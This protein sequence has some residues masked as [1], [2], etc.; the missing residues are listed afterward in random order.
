M[1]VQHKTSCTTP[2]AG[3][4]LA[5][6]VPGFVRQAAFGPR[7]LLRSGLLGLRT[8][9]TVAIFLG[10]SCIHVLFSAI[11]KTSVS[12]VVPR[13]FFIKKIPIFLQINSA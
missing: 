1:R 6:H 9:A 10:L 3:F 12:T 2:L 8:Y 13:H 5:A 7:M 11:L 4:L